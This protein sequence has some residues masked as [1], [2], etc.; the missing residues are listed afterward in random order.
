V[1][2]DGPNDIGP[3]REFGMTMAF[4]SFAP[5]DTAIPSEDEEL[6]KPLWDAT[7]HPT[8]SPV[9]MVP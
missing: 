3:L 6:G 8:P 4:R 9:I 5:S 1:I 2:D 7:F